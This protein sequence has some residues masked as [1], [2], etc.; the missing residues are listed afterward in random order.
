MKMNKRNAGI[1]GLA[2][3]LSGCAA[4]H[5][6]RQATATGHTV[7]APLAALIDSLP[8]AHTGVLVQQAATGKVLHS[9]NAHRLFVPASNTK[10][11]SMYAGLR[12]LPDTLPGLQYYTLGDT[13]FALPTADPTLLAAD[14]ATHP[15][16]DWL[17]QQSQPVVVHT[18]RWRAERYGR[19]WTWSDYQAS[20]QQERSAL[21]VLGNTMPLRV[22]VRTTHGPQQL[23]ALQGM[24]TGAYPWQ[25][26]PEAVQW[27]PSPERRTVSIRRQYAGNHLEVQYPARDTTASLSYPYVTHGIETGL[28]LLR[29][30]T[31]RSTATLRS[32]PAPV[33][34]TVAL[35][36]IGSQP[37]D[38][39]LRPMMHRSDNFFAEQ[40]LLMA[41]GLRLGYLSDRQMIDTLLATDLKGMPDA[42]VWADGSGLSRYNMFSPAAF[43]WLLGKM[44]NEFG[45]PRLQGILPTGNKGTLT[46]YYRPLEGKMFAKTG[47]LS[48]QVALSGYLYAQSGQLLLFS[49]LVNNH[50]MDAPAVRR[51]VERFLLQ[52]YADH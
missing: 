41:G 40:T 17:R 48:G 52:M 20:Y 22:V 29:A 30:I 7:A 8:M 10:L 49:V 34:A 38:S 14:Y 45:M 33:P 11:L 36:T 13:L 5:T 42:P 4:T 32:T 2:L 28:G 1:A 21:P 39:M 50:N 46:N 26:Q 35:S 19:G 31:G 23:Q 12:Y 6:Q 15:V 24:W 51:H 37:L 18:T 9:W 43:V 16:L 27:Q 3:L 25:L 47:T 44:K